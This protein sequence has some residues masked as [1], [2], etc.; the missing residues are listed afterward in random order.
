MKKILL[1]LHDVTPYFASEI[2]LICRRFD[3]LGALRRTLLVVPD[4]MRKTPIAGNPAWCRTISA[5]KASG[6][7]IGLH[8]IYH[9][10]AE[11]GRLSLDRART[12]LAASRERFCDAMGYAPSGFVAPQ[13]FQ[14]AGCKIALKELG[15]LYS[16]QWRGLYDADGNLLYR[17][18]PT[19]FD[20]GNKLF[21]G[22]FAWWNPWR[23]SHKKAGVIR[24]SVHP[25][26][27]RHHLI[28]GELALLA[29]LIDAGWSVQSYGDAA[30]EAK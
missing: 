27:V 26:D 5:M 22:F 14:S 4:Y 3:E 23:L 15:F 28:D 11:C 24:F 8:G 19:N 18:F 21:D 12:E 29:K 13:W 17:A 16:G 20:W 2:E 6:S 30:R 9:E 25:M 1:S 7:D 10:Y